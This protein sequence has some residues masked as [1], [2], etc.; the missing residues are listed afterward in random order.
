VP[1][2]S[3][4]AIG[5]SLLHPQN[6][7]PTGSA[8]QALPVN[9]MRPM[10]G[11]G[12]D[13][14]LYEFATSS[15]YHSLLTRFIDRFSH[16]VN[17]SASY[18]FSKALET[19]D[20]YSNQIDAFVNPRSRN[21]GPVGFDRSHVFSANFLW[22]IPKPSAGLRFRP[23]HWIGD[24]WALSGVTRMMT[25][26]KFTPTYQ[27]INSLPTPTGSSSEAARPQVLDPEAPI[28]TCFGPAP[29][30]TAANPAPQ[31][32]NLGKNTFTGQGVNNWDLSLYKNL[33]FR[34]GRLSGQLRF[35]T[36]N[37]FNHSQF[38]AVDTL[39][40]F[41]STGSA[42]LKLQAVRGYERHRGQLR[43]RG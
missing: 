24:N 5:G 25:G 21:Y 1:L 18:T 29:Q 7:D 33:R 17:A 13:V 22:N 36:Y 31:I 23:A 32:G 14:L 6:R 16:G 2:G 9:F 37:T 20:S 4:T 30:P 35:E 27:P 12:D 8:T 41:N 10:Q 42:T 19:A 38:S 43:Q 39:L 28:T 3:T 15:N 11:L 26:G 40:Q 34:E